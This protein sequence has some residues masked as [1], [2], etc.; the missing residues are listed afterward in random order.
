MLLDPRTWS[1]A[2]RIDELLPRLPARRPRARVTAE[3]HGSAF[4]VQTGVA[5]R[6]SARRS[7]SSARSGSS[8]PRRSRRSGCAP[9]S[10][11]RTRSRSGRRS[12]SPAASATSSS[13][14]RCASS[15]AA[16]RPSRCTSTSASPD[17]ETAI[18]VNDRMR[19]HLPLLLALSANSPFWQGRD[20]G[21]ASART[22]LF[23]A[24]PRVGVPRAFGNYEVYAETVD[25]LIRTE[26]VPEATFLWW[27]VR[28]QPSARH[29]RGPGHGRADAL[30][31]HR[32]HRRAGRSRWSRWRPSRATP[33]SPRSPPRR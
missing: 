11:A 15:P 29:G 1:L 33:A 22:P 17:A 2:H 7:T 32:R 31:R 24:F 30:R 21:L 19:V 20:S 8:S 10:P 26:A 4:E 13:T 6:R 27:D 16:S 14:A 18:R 23:Q 25:L 3:T 9:P 12:R 28:P 5:G